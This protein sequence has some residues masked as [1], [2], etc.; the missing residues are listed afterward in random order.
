MV[1]GVDAEVRDIFR[2]VTLPEDTERTQSQRRMADRV[3]YG[4]KMNSTSFRT[5]VSLPSRH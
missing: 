1:L 2:H 3:P 4:P 5:S